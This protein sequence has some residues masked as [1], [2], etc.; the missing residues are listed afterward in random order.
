MKSIDLAA[1]APLAGRWECTSETA[2]YAGPQEHGFAPFGVAISNVSVRSAVI[3]ATVTLPK[4]QSVGRIVFGHSAETAAYFSAGIG[5]YHYAYLLDEYVPGTGW[6]ALRT[7]GSENNLR[8]GVP[9][10]VEVR[11]RDRRV[12][13]LVNAVTVLEGTLPHPIVGNRIGLFAWG[14][15]P[16]EF[17]R[18]EVEVGKPQAFVVMQ[19]TQ[20]YDA[21]FDDVIAP[22]AVREG[23]SAYRAADVHRPGVILEDIVE[24]LGESDVVV[25][26]I[27]PPNENVFYEIGYA[28]AVG[29]PIIFLAEKSFRN[30]L[31]FDISGHRVIFYDDTIAGKKDVEE[32]LRK[33][34]ASVKKAWEML[35]WTV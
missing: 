28:H 30:K 7:E 19:F 32:S 2:V 21:L 14:D 25:A 35:P 33:H 6:R 13:L 22:V 29:K 12:A 8:P 18:F 1:L 17:R 24:G 34:L 15:A 23:F 9:Y 16:V 20:P 5:G 27:T 31:P 3:R 26:E 10:N 4:Q 11:I